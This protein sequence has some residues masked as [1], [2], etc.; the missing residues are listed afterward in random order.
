MA[1][2]R[3]TLIGCGN[4]GA[5]LAEGWIKAGLLSR[6]NIV[7][8]SEI[9]D[10]FVNHDYVFHVKQQRVMDLNQTE[11]ETDI[12][13]LAVKPQIMDDVLMTLQDTLPNNV[14]VLSIAAGKNIQSFQDILGQTQPIIRS[15]PNTPAAVGKG[16]TAM[17]G[18][19]I[20]D[21]HKEMANA[22]FGAVGE[23][24]WL[25]DENLMDAVTAI[26]GSGP[27]YVFYLTEALAGAGEK[28][29]LPADQAMQLARQT[30][31]GA[32]RL[33]EGE[34]E[35]QTDNNNNAVDASTLRRNVTSPGGTTEAALNVLMDGAFQKILDEAVKAARDRGKELSN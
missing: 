16:I 4:M 30:I 3:V 19:N 14:P 9:P 29:G 10:S 17:I 8:P 11:S 35:G 13:I 21:E 33:M 34:A 28:I 5:A 18:V 2:Y 15:M 26:S 32:A 12:I 22:L 31:I 6:L 24:I 7:D 20:T 23:T 27:A 1:Q 25:D